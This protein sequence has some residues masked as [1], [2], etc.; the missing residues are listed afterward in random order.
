MFMMYLMQVLKL[1]LTW[2]DQMFSF[3]ITTHQ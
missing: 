1:N 2:Y 3:E